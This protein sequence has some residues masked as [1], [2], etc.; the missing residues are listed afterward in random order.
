M[1][2]IT[3]HGNVGTASEV[4]IDV[5]ID[6]KGG[7]TCVFKRQPTGQMAWQEDEDGDKV[8]V[9]LDTTDEEGKYYKRTE[10]LFDDEQ[11]V[12]TLAAME[13]PD[14]KRAL[15]AIKDELLLRKIADELIHTPVFERSDLVL[16]KLERM[17]ASKKRQRD[18]AEKLQALNEDRVANEAADVSGGNRAAIKEAIRA[19]KK[20]AKLG[21]DRKA[22]EKTLGRKLN[23]TEFSE[24]RKQ[25][26]S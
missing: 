1:G 4:P 26:A 5:L 22:L 14:F 11:L 13:E 8:W 9:Y 20:D 17:D 16:E 18:N 24:V 12:P 6:E 2:W 23:D 15:A 7:K 3:Y 10:K 25:I 19:I 21:T